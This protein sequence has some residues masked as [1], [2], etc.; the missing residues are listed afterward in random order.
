MFCSAAD[1]GKFTKDD[2]PSGPWRDRF[3]RISAADADGT[4]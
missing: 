2:Y 4:V 3:F 1:E